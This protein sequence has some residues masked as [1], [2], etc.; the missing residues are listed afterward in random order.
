MLKKFNVFLSY[1]EFKHCLKFKYNYFNSLEHV[2]F[3]KNVLQYFFYDLFCLS[4]VKVDIILYLFFK[5]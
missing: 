1:S 5:R 2:Q 4:A 3:L